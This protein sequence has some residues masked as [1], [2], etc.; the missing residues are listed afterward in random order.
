MPVFGTVMDAVP[1]ALVSSV[2]APLGGLGQLVDPQRALAA[3][4][5]CTLP[6]RRISGCLTADADEEFDRPNPP[7][8][9][10]Y[11]S[12]NARLAAMRQY[13]RDRRARARLGA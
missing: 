7:G 8:Q 2:G 5:A 3:H 10:G 1:S 12:Y 11:V 9:R 6:S 4:A 13:M